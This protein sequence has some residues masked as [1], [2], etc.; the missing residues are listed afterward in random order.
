MVAFSPYPLGALVHLLQKR[1]T[2]R[3][4]LLL[5]STRTLTLEISEIFYESKEQRKRMKDKYLP[6]I[7][8]SQSSRVLHTLFHALWKPSSVTLQTHF[9]LTMLHFPATIGLM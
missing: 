4:E 3:F 2:P 8:S 1:K 6:K 9:A 5:K 7:A